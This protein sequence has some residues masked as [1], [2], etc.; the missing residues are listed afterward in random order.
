MEKN[1]ANFALEIGSSMSTFTS[2][3]LQ[4]IGAV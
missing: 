3:D 2:S 4:T 1:P